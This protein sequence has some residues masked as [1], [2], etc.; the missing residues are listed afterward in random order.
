VI[1]SFKDINQYYESAGKG[2]M[3]DP[4]ILLPHGYDLVVIH[5]HHYLHGEP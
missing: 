3:R 1:Q 2:W 4:F 5:I